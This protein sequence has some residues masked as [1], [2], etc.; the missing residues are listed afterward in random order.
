MQVKELKK[1]GLTHELEIT[2]TAQDIDKRIDSR[3]QEVSG[4]VRVPG[5]RPGKVP[6]N[7]MKKRYGKAI[8]GEVLELT[9]NE[10]TDQVMK[11]KGLKPAVRPK[12]EVKEF[13]EGKDL[14]YTVSVEVLPEVKIGDFKGLKLQKLVAKVDDAKINETLERIASSNESSEEITTKRAAKAGDIVVIDFAGRT[15]DDDV[16]HPGMQAQGHH[17][18]LGSN[19]FIAGFEDQLIGKK[20]GE[21]VEVKVAFPESYHAA[22]LAG[23]DAIFD[24][25]IK[26]IREAVPAKVDEQ[27]AKN[28]GFSDLDG[29][30]NAVGEQVQKELDAH[31]RIKLKKILLDQLDEMHAFEVPAT[32]LE[33]EYNA[34]IRQIEMEQQ[35]TGSTA[36]LSDDEKAELK[37]IAARRVRL[38]LVLSE[39]GNANKITV[40]DPELQKAVIAEAQRYPGQERH[41]FDYYSKNRQAL[42]SLRAP[43]FEEKV[44][45]FI[46]ELSKI[47]EKS[48][49]I[50]ELTAEEDDAEGDKPKA[51]KKAPAKDKAAASDEASEDAP[52]KKAPAKK[53]KAE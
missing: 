17:L 15:A 47:D 8:L 41:V 5:F 50:E 48:V 13:D 3:L 26:S 1:E 39:I 21:S 9:V 43:L 29:L 2:V 14:K 22:E 42:E 12:I 38:G 40:A 19:Q 45:D 35:Q 23:R 25:E 32:M 51:K 31:S 10:A 18:K 33:M 49:S 53:K 36:K 4:N 27:L 20:A 16:A 34:I 7:I 46:L 28:L 6:L 52:K 37:E 44:V 11:D 30:K 24:T